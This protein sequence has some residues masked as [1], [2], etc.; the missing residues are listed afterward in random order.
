MNVTTMPTMQATMIV[1][2]DRIVG[3]SGSDAPMASKMPRRPNATPTP[4]MMP[5]AEARTP[6]TMA[7]PWTDRR[8][9]T[10]SAPTVRSRASSFVRCPRTIEKVL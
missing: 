7:S 9:W 10:G 3:E 1:R 6:M 4:A 8:S 5:M 2:S